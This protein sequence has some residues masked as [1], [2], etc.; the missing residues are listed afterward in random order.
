MRISARGIGAARRLQRDLD[1]VHLEAVV[2]QRAEDHAAAAAE[3]EHARAGA[4]VARE[5]GDVSLAHPAHQAFDEALELATRL[6]VVFAGVEGFHLL[7][8]GHRMQSPEPASGADE[9]T[10][11][12]A[13]DREGGTGLLRAADE[14]RSHVLRRLRSRVEGF[15]VTLVQGFAAQEP[16]SRGCG[17]SCAA[18]SER[19]REC[20]GGP[21]DG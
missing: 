10:R 3:V 16:T 2:R 1:A 11:R 20:R 4:Q 6:T 18:G 12:Q 19:S 5:E 8:I 7:E 15:D 13:L 14:T 17:G 9:D 21:R